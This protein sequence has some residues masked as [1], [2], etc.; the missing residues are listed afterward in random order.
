MADA[1][2]PPQRL[3]WGALGPHRNKTHS[4]AR[5]AL[6]PNFGERGQPA[7]PAF[8]RQRL[9]VIRRVRRRFL[10]STFVRAEYVILLTECFS[11]VPPAWCEG[12]VIASPQTEVAGEQFIG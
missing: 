9:G 8:C 11:G 5:P 1:A 6:S 10:V 7:P 3:R 12:S 4:R 2:G